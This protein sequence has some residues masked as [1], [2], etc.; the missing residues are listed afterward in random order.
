MLKSISENAA[1]IRTRLARRSA[2][3]VSVAARSAA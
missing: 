2:H 3:L 1:R